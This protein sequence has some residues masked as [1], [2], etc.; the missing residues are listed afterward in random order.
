MSWDSTI[1]WLTNY[2]F[3]SHSRLKG[4]KCLKYLAENQGASG[5]GQ[6][7]NCPRSALLFEKKTTIKLPLWTSLNLE[8]NTVI[9]APL[10]L[11]DKLNY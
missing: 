6:G 4:T 1:N 5:R 8:P 7:A 3:K 11:S 9:L 2:T 10:H